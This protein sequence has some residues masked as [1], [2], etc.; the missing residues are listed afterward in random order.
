MS[1]L[2]KRLWFAFVVLALSLSPTPTPPAVEPS[3]AGGLSIAT[4]TL[5]PAEHQTPGAYLFVSP[6]TDEALALEEASGRLDSDTQNRF[7]HLA[8]DILTRIGL[9]RHRTLNAL[10]DWSDGVENSILV[11]VSPTPDVA[12]LRYAAAWAGLLANQKSVLLFTAGAGGADRVYHLDVPQA[13]ARR[14]RKKLDEHG[15]KFRTLVPLGRG[16]RVVVFDSGRQSRDPLDRLAAAY[17]IRLTETRGSGAFLGDDTR[18]AARRAFRRAIDEYEV[19]R[20][21]PRYRPV[22]VGTD[23]SRKGEKT[24]GKRRGPQLESPGLDCECSVGR[25]QG[26][27][28]ASPNGARSR[29]SCLTGGSQWVR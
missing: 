14:L 7:R 18:P 5:A 8:G 21:R 19:Q 15:I 28:L 16:H 12:A 3:P 6:N 23:S 25:W 17:G 29:G 1:R 20:H 13:D 11:E 2:F 27:P 24:V 9:R 22:V 4:A 26:P 10:G